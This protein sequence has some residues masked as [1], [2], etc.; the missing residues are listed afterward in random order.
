MRDF[1]TAVNVVL[2]DPRTAMAVGSI[3]EERQAVARD[4]AAVV[5]PGL[6]V[7]DTPTPRRP[8]P[9]TPKP[10]VA[11]APP[12][13]GRVENTGEPPRAPRGPD[14][15][16]VGAV[17]QPCAGAVA[18]WV[19]V[20]AYRNAATAGQ[21]AGRVKGEILV[22]PPPTAGEPLLRVRVGPFGSRAQAVARL[23]DLQKLGYQ[24]FV[25][26]DR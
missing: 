14:I 9:E 16:R 25:A 6:A 1:F 21:V 5:T 22:A 24:P 26:S 7:R 23:R 8:A 12:P 10:R 15:R 17:E 20:G 4:P 19:Q 13:T 3:T 2:P 11:P 18:F